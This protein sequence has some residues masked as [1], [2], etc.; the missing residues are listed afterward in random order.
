MEVIA[1]GMKV[2]FW[3][4]VEE[5]GD[6][7]RFIDEQIMIDMDRFMLVGTLEKV[8]TCKKKNEEKEYEYFKQ[9]TVQVNNICLAS[10][11]NFNIAIPGKKDEFLYDVKFRYAPEPE[12]VAGDDM[13]KVESGTDVEVE[14]QPDTAEAK[15]DAELDAPDSL[16]D[17]DF[18]AT[19]DRVDDE[20]TVDADPDADDLKAE[21]DFNDFNDDGSP[22]NEDGTDPDDGDDYSFEDEP[23]ANAI[24]DDEPDAEG[25]PLAEVLESD[26]DDDDGINWGD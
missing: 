19:A 15:A 17:L 8:S 10:D 3:V 5:E 13:E 23:A 22:A 24:V 16:D 6:I 7:D 4:P 18:E 12:Q 1:N 9:I 21:A 26:D 14:E 11:N 2:N 20:D 25:K